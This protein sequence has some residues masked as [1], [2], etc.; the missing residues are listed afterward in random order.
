MMGKKMIY[1]PFHIQARQ[2][3]P[4]QSIWW[5]RAK[6]KTFPEAEKQIKKYLKE[7]YYREHCK[8][9]IVEFSH[10][11]RYLRKPDIITRRRKNNET[12]D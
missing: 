11:I 7:R 4:T 10:N 9:R 5:T 6:F 8:L 12:C 1:K 2:I 3:H